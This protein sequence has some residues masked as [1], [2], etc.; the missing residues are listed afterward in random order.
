[1]KKCILITLLFVMSS[2]THAADTVKKTVRATIDKDGVQRVA[3]VG[4]SYF[5]D[6]ARIIVRVNVPVELS[7]RKEPGM[8]PHN[9][10]ISAVNA[11]IDFDEEMKTE[12]KVIRFTPTKVGSYPIYCSKK[13]LFF[14]SHREKG[15]EG[16]L[17]VVE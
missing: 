8:V 4:G 10:V 3:L 14:E 1:M 5:F 17:E 7:V 11:G 2:L 6:P 15:M 9:I 12:P 16:M 13:L